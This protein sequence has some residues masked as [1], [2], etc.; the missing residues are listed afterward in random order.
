MLLENVKTALEALFGNRLRS[1][2][3]LLGVVI[4][5]FAVTTTISMGAIATAGITSELQD[6]GSQSLFVV[7]DFDN[8]QAQ[9][10]NDDDIEALSRLPIDILQQQS[11]GGEIRFEEES[12]S[13]S[14][15]GTTANAAEVDRTLELDRGRYFSQAD[16]KNAAPVIVLSSDASQELFGDTVDPVGKEVAVSFGDGSRVFYTV[17]GVKK[18]IGGALGA[19]ANDVSGDIPLTTF[20]NDVPG[21]TRG[22]YDFL[23]ITIDLDRNAN[24]IEAQVRAILDRRRGSDTYT[25]QT[26]EGA[27]SLFN[28]ITRIL[29][30][31]LGGIGAISLLVGGIGILNIMLVS[32]TERT[33]EIG[34]RKALGAKRGTILQ[35]FLIEAVVLTVIGGLI[36][37]LLSIG[38]LYLIVAAVPFLD[39]VIISPAVILMAFGVS[40]IT[41]VIFGVWPASRAANLS[42]I[43]ALRYE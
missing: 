10:F 34:L 3:T 6:F 41:G 16:E 11:T 5:V 35:Q 43:E 28:T 24:D 14:L 2:L 7:V 38:V 20:Y 19:F 1:V 17:I 23:P 29:Q 40:V 22:E 13:I 37:V 30:A 21:V 42:P 27:L 33:R 32:V 9:R 12:S 31:V 39:R 36:G 8:P 26:I 25:I 18:R 15:N 4:G